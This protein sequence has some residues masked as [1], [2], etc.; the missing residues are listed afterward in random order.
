M[1]V[2]TSVAK[3][4]SSLAGRWYGFRLIKSQTGSIVIAIGSDQDTIASKPV[5]SPDRIYPAVINTAGD[6][7]YKLGGTTGNDLTKKRNTS[8]AS[9]LTG[10]DGEVMT[11]FEPFYYRYDIIVDGTTTY[12]D[13]K[14][15]VNPIPGFTRMPRFFKGIYPAYYDSVTDKLRS[16]S[17]VT[18]TTNERRSWYRQKAANVGSGW[19]IEPYYADNVLYHLLVAE[20][21][22]LNTQEDISV[23]AANAS[24][25]DWNTFCGGYW[26]V[27]TADG[28][29]LSSY[30]DAGGVLSVASPNAADVR[31]GEI[32]LTI[33][34]WG[35]GT[36]TLNTQIAV[37]WHVRDP[38]GHTWKFK[39]GINIHNSSANGARVFTSRKAANFADDT[40]INHNLI[41]NIAENDG[42]VSRFLAGH[43]LPVETAGSSSQH[44]GDYYYTYYDNSPDSGWRVA[45]AGGLLHY[46]SNAGFACFRVFN[47]SSDDYSYVGARLCK[48]GK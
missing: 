19:C 47:G 48:I 15:S 40:D 38:W 33:E 28:G 24:S 22:N 29:Q 30:A 27:W 8:E 1:I 16:V 6:I 3:S 35:D 13:W 44:V 5:S 20:R 7:V 21:L 37:M 42:Y 14:F 34:N 39:D 41:G 4:V 23:G 31:T 10:G 32:P 25:G 17:G 43:I 45:F 26:P 36:L 12:E 11:V 2:G 18:P 9:D 46:G